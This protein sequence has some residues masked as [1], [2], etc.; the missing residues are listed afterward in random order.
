MEVAE[1]NLAQLATMKQKPFRFLGLAGKFTI[2][3]RTIVYW[4]ERPSQWQ[5][6]ENLAG[7]SVSCLDWPKGNELSPL[8]P[9][10]KRSRGPAQQDF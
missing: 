3:G 5:E 1:W 6:Q 2:F 7:E 9:D 8:G 10:M 4:D